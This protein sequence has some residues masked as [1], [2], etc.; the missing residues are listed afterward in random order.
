M[1]T[2]RNLSFAVLALQAGLIDR[3]QF[4]EACTIWAAG[5]TAPVADI[6]VSRGWIIADDRA[7]LNYLLDR[8]LGRRGSG[9]RSVLATAPDDVK[10]SLAAL[11]DPD[12][13][14]SLADLPPTEGSLDATV[15]LATGPVER[16]TL[17]RLHAT[18]G[19]G[20]VSV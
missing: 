10:R 18:G 1:D 7:H 2:D 3:A 15:D 6:L 9:G 17:T 20:R 5:K 14:Q 8:K 4:V 16:Y 11:G 19:I 12:I 13:Q